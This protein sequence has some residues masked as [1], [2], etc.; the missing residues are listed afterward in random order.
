MEHCFDVLKPTGSIYLHCDWH[1]GHYLK[2]MMDKVFGY[3]NLVNEIIWS[4]K[5][6]GA[7]KKQFSKKHDTI[8]M[9]QKSKDCR[10][11]YRRIYS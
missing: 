9:Y 2:Q 3:D 11:G 6:G 7:S 1:A 4:Y 8:F 10:H 5:T